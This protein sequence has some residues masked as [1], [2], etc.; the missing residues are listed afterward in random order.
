MINKNSKPNTIKEKIQTEETNAPVQDVLV[1]GTGQKEKN[2]DNEK[3]ILEIR[4]K[5]DDPEYMDFAIY[6]LALVITDKICNVRGEM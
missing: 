3:S 5:L 1:Q 4:S 2:K 6:R